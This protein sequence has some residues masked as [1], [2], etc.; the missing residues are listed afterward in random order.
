MIA[1]SGIPNTS[2][3]KLKLIRL[4]KT[5]YTKTI[6]LILAI[7]ERGKKVTQWKPN[8]KFSACEVINETSTQTI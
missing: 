7:S 3:F 5:N 2:K 1:V 6:L 8:N 4:S